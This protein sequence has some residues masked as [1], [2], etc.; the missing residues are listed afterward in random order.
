VFQLDTGSANTFLH[1]PLLDGGADAQAKVTPDAGRVELGCDLVNIVGIAIIDSAPVNGKPC[2]GTLGN[3]RLL[4]RPVKLDLTA[5]QV[6]W[7]EPGAPFAEAAS[8]PRTAFDRPGGYVRIHDVTFDGT[9]VTLLVDT[10]S[11][12]SLWVG[13]QGR[14]GDQQIEGE[15]AQG[16][17]IQVY[18]GTVTVGIGTFRETVPVFRAPSFPY[19]ANAARAVGAHVDGMFGLSAFRHGLVLDTDAK[20][21]RV[22][23]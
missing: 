15:D 18:W 6:V 9:P 22:A 21:V 11:P 16:D 2:V 1:E 4:A 12:D 13:Q 3:D 5:N 17:I 23:P 20:L 7:N 19:L 14:P 10:G 8:W